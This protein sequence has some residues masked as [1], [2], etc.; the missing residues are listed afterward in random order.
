MAG[1]GPTL[2]HITDDLELHS[3]LSE[4]GANYALLTG[5]GNLVVIDFDDDAIFHQW[6]KEAGELANTFTVKTRRGFYVYYFCDDIRSWRG[7]GFEVMGK[8]K[9]VMGPM[10]SHPAGG[11]YKPLCQ[12]GI[13]P[14][15]TISDFPLLSEHRPKLA[16]PP[17][18]RPKRLGGGVVQKIKREWLITDLIA[19]KPKL[20]AQIRLKSSDKQQGRWYAG[21]CPFHDDKNKKS[22]WVDAERNLYGCHAC[23]SR[24]DVINFL[25]T[26]EGWTVQEA[27]RNMAKGAV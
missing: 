21:F 23:G 10:S 19:N 6:Q 9:A 8:G 14:M 17:R 18:I 22:L 24:G 16:Q 11:K 15:D 7:D 25:A 27:I 3:W 13:R 1:Y 26:L 5:T 12:P 4:R 20:S 2:K